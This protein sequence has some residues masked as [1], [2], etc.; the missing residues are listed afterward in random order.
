[1]RRSLYVAG[2]CALT[3]SFLGSFSASGISRGKEIAQSR[4]SNRKQSSTINLKQF[5][6]LVVLSALNT[7]Y[8]M[9]QQSEY[10]K[11]AI[12][13]ISSLFTLIR[14]KYNGKV[15]GMPASAKEPKTLNT[16]IGG[17]IIIKA[18][19]ICPEKLPKSV[20]REV[21]RIQKKEADRK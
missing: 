7:C 18:T 12:P 1:M 20:V 10:K 4:Q 17:N 21:E 5:D 6:E 11:A 19:F 8:S 15:E 2:L 3:T 9:T 13:A 14:D 16:W